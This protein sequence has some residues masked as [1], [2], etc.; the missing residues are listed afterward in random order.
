MALVDTPLTVEDGSIVTGADSFVSAD[1]AAQYLYDRGLITSES[2]ITAGLLRRGLDALLALPCLAAY[3]LPLASVTDI[4]SELVQ[5]Q[6]WVAYYISVSASNDPAAITSGGT[7]KREK[8]DVIER[9]YM[10]CDGKKSAVSIADM[11]SVVGL[12]R[13]MGCSSMT[14]NPSAAP[15]AM[16]V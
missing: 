1:D 14:I 8:V 3:R 15:A 9:E 5:A 10:D 13:A 16:W 11:P 7:V 12:L 6:T 4:P 2:S